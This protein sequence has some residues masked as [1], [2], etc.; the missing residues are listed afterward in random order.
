MKLRSLK[1]LL[2]FIPLFVILF[3]ILSLNYWSYF[4]LFFIFVFIPFIELFTNG[5]KENLSKIQKEIA[6]NNKL[7]DFWLYLLVPTH[8][9]NCKL[10]RTSLGSF[11]HKKIINI[12]G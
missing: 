9:R 2:M 8:I 12:N 7:Y 1:Y 4:V 5:F 11:D 10:H 6:C 3:S